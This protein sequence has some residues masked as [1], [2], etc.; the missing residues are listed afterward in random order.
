MLEPDVIRDRGQGSHT[1]SVQATDAA[2]NVSA[3]ASWTWTIDSVRPPAPVITEH[4]SD[5]TPAATTTFAWTGSGVTYQCNRENGAWQ[6]CSSPYTY[7]VATTSN[8]QHQFGVRAIDAAGNVSDN[9]SFTWKV[10]ESSPV[11]F[12]IAGSVSGLALGTW[13]PIPVTLTNPNSAAIYVTALAVTLPADS[14]PSG[15]SPSTNLELQQASGL[16]AAPV[17]VPAHGSASVPAAQQPSLRLRDLATNQDVCKSK[18]FSLSYTGTA[19]N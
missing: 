16:S 12:Q 5:P 18:G 2:G 13:K 6:P 3:A 9:T 7:I 15:C 8:G 19:G 17:R 1:F 10:Q 11:Q 14:T 4:P